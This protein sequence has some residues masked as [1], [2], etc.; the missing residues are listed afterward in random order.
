MGIT[1]VLGLRA[2]NRATLER[3]FLLRKAKLT[4]LEAIE[5]L[6]GLQA[7]APFPPY[8][9][10]R[11]RLAGFRPE[12][13]SRL[14][15]E[16]EVVRIVLM[17]GTVHLVTAADALAWRPLVQV[18]MDRDLLANTLHAAGLGGLDFGE[19]AAEARALLAT[20]TH[21]GKELGVALAERWTD[22]EPA[23]LTHAARGLLPLVQVPPRGIWGKA[24]QPAYATAE[25]WLG[26]PLDTEP[27]PE[28]L[29]ERYLAAFGPASVRDAQTWAGVTKLG[30]VFGRMPLR[31]FRSESGVELFDLPDAPR[32]DPDTPAPARLL[33][34][35]DQLILS[36]ADRSRVITDEH[37]KRVITQNGLVKGTLLV[38]GQITGWW[39]I[40]RKRDVATVRL[41]PFGALGKRDITALEREG[42]DLLAF[43]E[44]DATHDL[45]WL[46]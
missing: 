14:I 12:Q 40:Q 21:T 19:V 42:A 6:G 27:S 22:R 35:F 10:L 13:L 8:F 34:P 25:D 15:E 17:R 1:E 32:P 11:A 28:R 23:S 9:G 33:G 26:R 5:R 3:Q 4:A 36:Y 29:V 7:Q 41:T 18:I 30:E 39:E 44:P 37:R 16:R 46:D 43:A 31:T 45:Q 20:R 24:G 2:L 38:D